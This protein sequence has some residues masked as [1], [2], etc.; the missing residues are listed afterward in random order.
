MSPVAAE[1]SP[2]TA[3]IAHAFSG[4]RA[5]GARPQQGRVGTAACACYSLAPLTRYQGSLGAA[6][7]AGLAGHSWPPA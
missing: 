6:A 7:Q 2:R 3:A 4:A 5:S 1:R